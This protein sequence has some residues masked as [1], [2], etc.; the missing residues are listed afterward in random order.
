MPSYSGN[1]G[2]RE[3]FGKNQYLRSTKDV[4][5]DSYT[6]A[7]GGIPTEDID[8]DD[9]K[10]LQPGTLIAAITSGG[11]SGKVGVFDSGASDGRQ[12][13]ANIVGVADT[14]LPW[15]LNERDAEIAVTY[16]ATCVQAWCFEYVAGVRTAL[17]NATRDAVVA[18]ETND[19]HF[20]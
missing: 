10:V 9:L 11:D 5:T 14:F 4:K 12:T 6:M 16:E 18:L 3:P 13:A 17:T 8:G 15:E 19:L 2:L 1:T 20:R 7:D